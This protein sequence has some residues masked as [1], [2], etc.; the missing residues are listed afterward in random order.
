MSLPIRAI[1]SL[2]PAPE[3]SRPPCRFSG[4]WLVAAFASALGHAAHWIGAA[5]LI[6]TGAYG[7]I[8]AIRSPHG[9]ED[10]ARP[11]DGSA[12]RLIITR[13]ALSID[14]LA[15]GFALGTY[16]VS[17]LLAVAVIGTVSIVM[18]P[19]GLELGARIGRRAGQRGELL[20]GLV[21]IGVGIA[22]GTGS[23]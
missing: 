14:N 19:A 2:S 4:C 6:A 22:I 12:G 13:A 8:E 15:V 9:E 7:V 17:L 21:L 20:G 18:S 11:P 5:L 10:R 3:S 16:H 1:K 23:V